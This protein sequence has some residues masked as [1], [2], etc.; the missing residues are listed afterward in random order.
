M[1]YTE[2]LELGLPEKSENV[3]IDV[4]NENNTKID[5]AL[6][7][8]FGVDADGNYGYYKD[9]ADTVTP[10]KSGGSSGINYSTEEQDTG[11]KW[12]DGRTV[13]QKTYHGYASAGQNYTIL[14]EGFSSDNELI[15]FDGWYGEY[16]VAFYAGGTFFS[17]LSAFYNGTS[18]A[19]TYGSSY[20]GKLYTI[21]VR[22][23]KK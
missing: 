6:P 15:G 20:R 1:K 13:Y 10:F 22:Y 16:N 4:I 19:I 12:I 9:G 8:K 2:N 3:S 17:Y 18:L 11:L 14:Q 5:S 7:F 23:V 21:T